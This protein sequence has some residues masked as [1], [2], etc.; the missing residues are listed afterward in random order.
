MRRALIP[1]AVLTTVIVIGIVL[2][3]RTAYHDWVFAIGFGGWAELS[4]T[5]RNTRLAMG[6]Q[7]R[8]QEAVRTLHA[9]ELRDS[10]AHDMRAHPLADTQSFRVLVT[11][12]A[13]TAN[14]SVMF[15]RELERQWRQLNIQQ[16]LLPVFAVIH[17]DSSRLTQQTAANEVTAYEA[18]GSDIAFAAPASNA[19][20]CLTVV[21]I[22]VPPMKSTGSIDPRRA[23]L[24]APLLGPCAYY[25]AFGRPGRGIEAWLTERDYD[26]ARASWRQSDTLL[27]QRPDATHL[28]LHPLYQEMPPQRPT[29][30]ELKLALQRCVDGRPDACGSLVLDPALQV[31][32][33]GT[34]DGS[35]LPIGLL[36]NTIPDLMLYREGRIPVGDRFLAAVVA[37]STHQQFASLWKADEPVEVAFRNA[38]GQPIG[39]WVRN[40]VHHTIGFTV[41]GTVVRPLT[42]LVS[43]ALLLAGFWVASMVATG[44]VIR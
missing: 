14:D 36:T 12:G 17:I 16:S 28:Y 13:A 9:Y 29:P 41:R 39:D 27:S 19:E 34:I 7:A 26:V 43:V 42:V 8:L 22:V 10:I 3:S 23:A 6:S 25:A 33:A 21:R 11:G 5:E 40:W 32:S 1:G 4:S 35:T 30:A 37:N 20:T 31:R 24:T 18:Q 2:R 44:R 38:L 15:T